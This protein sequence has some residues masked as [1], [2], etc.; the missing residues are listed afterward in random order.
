[1]AA[2]VDD[3][4][5]IPLSIHPDVMLELSSVQW[6][7]RRSIVGEEEDDNDESL[8]IEF[9]VDGPSE[10]S[11]FLEKI[12]KK[13]AMQEGQT[14]ASV[15]VSGFMSPPRKVTINGA[16]ERKAAG[17]P[18]ECKY[19][20]FAYPLDCL[21]G[22]FD[23]LVT[24]EGRDEPW[25]NF[26]LFGGYVYF[27][28]SRRLVRSNAIVLTQ[29]MAALELVGP[30]IPS[31]DA[32]EYLRSFDRLRDV[33]L[34]P[35]LD[36]GFQQFGWVNPGERPGGHPVLADGTDAPGDGT[37]VYVV[38]SGG[39]ICY[40][41][42]KVDAVRKQR[43]KL[44]EDAAA[45]REAAVLVGQE[46][47]RGS[48]EYVTEVPQ[49]DVGSV[50]FA[51]AP[52]AL[53]GA[54]PEALSGGSSG[55]PS[56]TMVRPALPSSP[57]KTVPAAAAAQ[58]A[59]FGE[60]MG[61][62]AIAAKAT[63]EAANKVRVDLDKWRRSSVEKWVRSHGASLVAYYTLGVLT[64][65]A[66]EGWDP[67]DS[68]Y[69]LTATAT[70]NGDEISPQSP[71][72]RLFSCFYILLGITI[73]FSGLAPLAEYVLERVQRAL[74]DPLATSLAERSEDVLEAIERAAIRL[75]ASTRKWP[76][77]L[78]CISGPVSSAA[79]GVRTWAN[80]H[81]GG[82]GARGFQMHNNSLRKI[83]LKLPSSPPASPPAADPD[84]GE[85]SIN[86][87]SSPPASPPAADPQRSPVA[88]PGGRPRVGPGPG[89]PLM[90]QKSTPGGALLQST[91]P[92]QLALQSPH[93][94][95]FS[96]PPSAPEAMKAAAGMP[97]SGI[98][99]AKSS[100]PA[101]EALVKSVMQGALQG[102][103]KSY[104]LALMLVL[105]VVALGMVIAMGVHKYSTIDALYWTIGCMTTAGGDLHADTNTLK[106]VYI[107]YMPLGAVTMLTA[108][109]TVLISSQRRGIT[110]DNFSLQL[111]D[112]LGRE[113]RRRTNK[114]AK[115][116]EA[117]FIVSVLQ[118]RKMVD[119]QT[120]EVI[121]KQFAA[122]VPRDDDA[123]NEPAIDVQL[124]FDNLV[125][126]RR[127]LSDA[128]RPKGEESRPTTTAFD[129]E[130]AD[131]EKTATAYVDMTCE[132]NG[133]AEWFETYWTPSVEGAT[134]S[135]AEK[136]PQGHWTRLRRGY[137]KLMDA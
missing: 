15:S 36:A 130:D 56:S 114:H 38:E 64:Y 120:I 44:L 51:S 71:A 45:A 9:E 129:D 48:P 59:K 83:E 21:A 109:R 50:R 70:T 73:I 14:A 93:G 67:L 75:Q 57:E 131:A 72:G 17:I 90:R 49:R 118:A 2:N 115:L 77:W 13:V 94:A 55:A 82:A 105:V 101:G 88:P 3:L 125:R 85:I 96:H 47:E 46:P 81:T 39:S 18:L 89:A 99:S 110:M 58:H 84:L 108:G 104:A 25:L 33:T 87:T 124:V 92:A 43:Q 26:L 121:R 111:Y 86:L 12:K 91:Q 107:I 16:K 137:T 11:A 60:A 66:F 100:E 117:D 40:S 103:M 79:N 34:Q 127:V 62:L 10:V 52:E 76:S 132:D 134:G 68:V 42:V 28:A 6:Q 123:T 95:E 119:L 20:A 78:G 135:G 69:Y 29:A 97:T 5:S 22:M 65:G 37:F 116:R 24:R 41:L 128:L 31:Q 54:P 122:L 23:E 113:A 8:P 63:A 4:V 126:Q 106:M 133:F 53:S 136:G 32:V 30:F 80:G 27:D 7:R 19:F 61:Q 98:T 112:L 1:M 102:T 74:L 35:M